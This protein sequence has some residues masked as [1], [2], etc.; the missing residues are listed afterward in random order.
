MALTRDQKLDI[1]KKFAREKGDT[2]SPEVQVA[3][4]TAQIE[5]LAGHLKDHNKDTHSRRGL[6]SMVA[7]RRRLLA[8]LSK[9]DRER[10]EKL[11]A[12]LSI[13]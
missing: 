12:D 9:H 10:F 3:L 13:K 11:R 8:Y 2:G 1:I 4:L 7:K 5:S 6:L